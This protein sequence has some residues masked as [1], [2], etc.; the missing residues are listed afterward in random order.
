VPKQCSGRPN[1]QAG[2]RPPGLRAGAGDGYDGQQEPFTPTG[3]GRRRSRT[4]W[5]SVQ[6][7]RAKCWQ[8]KPRARC[9]LHVASATRWSAA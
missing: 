1:E 7:T 9:C 2:W 6:G 3:S 4:V 5:V 8:R